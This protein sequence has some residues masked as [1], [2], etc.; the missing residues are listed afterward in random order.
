MNFDKWPTCIKPGIVPTLPHQTSQKT[1]YCCVHVILFGIYLYFSGRFYQ[2]NQSIQIW[3]STVKKLIMELLQ[4]FWVGESL[5]AVNKSDSAVL[6]FRSA[7]SKNELD[8]I[9]IRNWLDF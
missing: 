6:G 8:T 2:F 7:M 3:L 4:S 9:I 1:K 5:A